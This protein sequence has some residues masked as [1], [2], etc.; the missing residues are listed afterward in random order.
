MGVRS[1]D[2][3]EGDGHE[4][5]RHGGDTGNGEYVCMALCMKVGDLGDSYGD[6]HENIRERKLGI[7]KMGWKDGRVCKAPCM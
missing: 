4:D 3:C 1:F 5:R 6:E 7:K 2:G